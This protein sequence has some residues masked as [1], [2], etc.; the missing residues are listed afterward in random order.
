MVGSPMRLQT[1]K[2]HTPLALYPSPEGGGANAVRV[3]SLAVLEWPEPA[4]RL[5]R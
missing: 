2:A 1:R 4:P 3:G 5:A